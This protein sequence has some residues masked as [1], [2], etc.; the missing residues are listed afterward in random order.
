MGLMGWLGTVWLVGV[1][2]LAA[3]SAMV[4]WGF[5]SFP[6]P[7][8]FFRQN[9]QELFR[10]HRS[11]WRTWLLV[12]F[13][14]ILL[15]PL[16]FMVFLALMLPVIVFST[17]LLGLSLLTGKSQTRSTFSYRV[18]RNGLETPPPGKP[19]LPGSGEIIDV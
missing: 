6:V 11:N 3:M 16:V 2:I 14:M 17:A 9:T 10:F 8:V 1:G 7:V 18:F 13:P 15:A 4:L 19:R 12:V 5:R